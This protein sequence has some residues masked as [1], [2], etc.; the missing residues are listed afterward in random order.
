MGRSLP[1]A[2]A[3]K[4]LEK[5]LPSA[6]TPSII[7][8]GRTSSRDAS[9]GLAAKPTF[10]LLAAPSAFAAA[11]VLAAISALAAASAA[12][13]F[14]RSAVIALESDEANGREIAV[15]FAGFRKCVTLAT[16][17]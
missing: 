2:P 12:I 5:R 1:I 16:G 17:S 9:L 6:F 7:C 14:T 15:L 3:A 4:V 11:S 13:F 10:A 8:E